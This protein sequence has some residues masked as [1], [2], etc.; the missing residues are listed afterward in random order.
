MVNSVFQT[1]MAVTTGWMLIDSDYK[2]YDD[3]TILNR[4]HVIV[5]LTGGT[6]EKSGYAI[7]PKQ[8]V[9][10]GFEH[11]MTRKSAYTKVHLRR[12]S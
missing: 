5:A 12:G 3:P 2:A 4:K 1:E 6:N 9:I 8:S 7:I 10:M 11:R